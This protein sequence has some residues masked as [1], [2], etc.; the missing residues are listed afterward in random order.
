[1]YDEYE[2]EDISPTENNEYDEWQLISETETQTI[3][4]PS[5]SDLPCQTNLSRVTSFNIGLTGPGLA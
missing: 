1:M 2:K 4:R 3:L 5:Y